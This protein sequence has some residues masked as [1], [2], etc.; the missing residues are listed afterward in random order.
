MRRPSVDL[1][2]DA[3]GQLR[4]GLCR[5][6]RWL[7]A[8]GTSG[9]AIGALGLKEEPGLRVGVKEQVAITLADIAH[10]D[11]QEVILPGVCPRSWRSSEWARSWSRARRARDLAPGGTHRARWTSSLGAIV[12]L[13]QLLERARPRRGRPP[14]NL[15]LASRRPNAWHEDPNSGV[16]RQK[17]SAPRPTPA[18]EGGT[19]ELPKASPP[20][21][22]ARMP[23]ARSPG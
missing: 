7:V 9:N 16:A 19:E 21:L 6:H 20:P 17:A 18:S 11:M 14:R 3:A 13:V 12:D 23:A 2:V 8:A 22:L 4:V 10:D 15:P 5:R 1:E